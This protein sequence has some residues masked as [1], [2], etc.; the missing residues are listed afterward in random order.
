MNP[1]QHTI[2][3]KKRQITYQFHFYP[4]SGLQLQECYRFAKTGSNERRP[5]LSLSVSEPQ[6]PHGIIK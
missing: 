1:T 3:P 2:K 6:T 4:G 5:Q